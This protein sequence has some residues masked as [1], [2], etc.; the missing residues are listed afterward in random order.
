MQNGKLD[1][2]NNLVFH[3]ST[4]FTAEYIG[5]SVRMIEMSGAPSVPRL[6]NQA[7]LFAANV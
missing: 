5:E 4:Q 3:F 7:Y 2:V 6:P 1:N